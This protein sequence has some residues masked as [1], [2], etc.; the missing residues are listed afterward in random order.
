MIVICLSKDDPFITSDPFEN[1]TVHRVMYFVIWG[2]ALWGNYAV[3]EGKGRGGGMKN[4]NKDVTRD[5][6]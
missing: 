5:L 1:P 3:G 2:C 4:A 6:S